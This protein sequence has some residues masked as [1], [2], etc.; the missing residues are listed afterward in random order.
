VKLPCECQTVK[1]YGVKNIICYVAK[2]S[3]F[4]GI[5]MPWKLVKFELFTYLT[6]AKLLF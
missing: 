5:K 4:S 2:S 3:L 6:L 1:I